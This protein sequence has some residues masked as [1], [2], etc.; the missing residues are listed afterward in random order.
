MRGRSD[1][2]LE[3]LRYLK[4]DNDAHFCL[5]IRSLAVAEIVV[6]ALSAADLLGSA[7]ASRARFGASPKRS[8]A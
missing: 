7:R 8:L 3:I 2:G 4:D 5:R 6:A 1:W